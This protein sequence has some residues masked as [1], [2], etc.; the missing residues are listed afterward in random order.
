MTEGPISSPILL[1][2]LMKY[3][4]SRLAFIT[5]KD[6]TQTTRWTQIGKV[7]D[8]VRKYSDC[9]AIVMGTL[10]GKHFH[11]LAGIEKNKKL[12]VRKGIHFDIQFLSKD[13]PEILPDYREI[14]RNKMDQKHV[15]RDMLEE[16]FDID[17][18]PVH[19]QDI[20]IATTA[21][22]KSYF[23]KIANK[24]SR[25][26]RQTKKGKDIDNILNYLQKNLDEYREDSLRQYTDYITKY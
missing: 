6:N 18:V 21:L 11:I 13:K 7:N 19:Q 15:R 10:G 16:L 20:I 3:P 4:L 25:D 23:L 14:A 9:Y 2:K 1:T 22:I 12:T 5:I 17:D 8:W 24:K 26:I